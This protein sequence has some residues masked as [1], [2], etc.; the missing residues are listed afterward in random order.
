MRTRVTIAAAALLLASA[1]YAQ[2]QGADQAAPAPTMG[3][4]DFGARATS[5]TGD[6]ARYERYRDLQS[7][8]Y[9]KLV[10]GKATDA[11]LLDVTGEN[12]GYANQ[13][14]SANY[15]NSKLKVTFGWNGIPLNYSYL[16][17]TPYAGPTISGE[18]A[19]YTLDPAVRQGVQEGT[20]F[21]RP[22]NAAGLATPSIYRDLAN[23][24]PL[25]QRRDVVNVGMAYEATRAVGLDVDFTSTRK[26][27]YQPFGAS[28]GFSDGVEMPYPLDQRTNDFSA[29][30]E[31]A[32]QKGMMRVGHQASY[33][34]NAVETMIWD[35][36]VWGP[37]DA[38]FSNGYSTGN[39]ASKG[40]MA[41]PPDNHQNV[42]S[43]TGLYKMPAHTTLNGIFA[44]TDQSQDGR[45]IPF[46]INTA[47]IDN[48]TLYPLHMDRLTAQAQVR[49]YNLAAN[50]NSRPN[51]AI[52]FTLKYRYNKH[53]NLTPHFNGEEYVRFDQ[54][55]EETGSETEQ[56]D[57]TRNTFDAALAFNLPA[58]TTFRVGYGYDK[59]DRTGRGFSGMKDDTFRMSLDTVGNQY[60]T[61]RGAFEHVTRTGE[62][63]SEAS[64]EEGGGQPNLRFYDEADRDRDRASVTVMIT[65]VPMVSINAAYASGKDT[66]KGE[67]HEFGLLD[68]DTTT[69]S[70]G[71]DVSPT[72]LVMFG[73]SYGRDEFTS[74]QKSRNAN[75]PPD[76]SWTDPNRDWYLDN[77]E[78]VNNVDFYLDL[79]KLAGTTDVRFDYI[80]SD[81]DNAFVHYGPRITALRA[82]GQSEALPNVTNKWQRFSADIKYFFT[83]KAGIG[84]GYWYEKFDVE[85]FATIDLPGHDGE[86]RV[87]YLGGLILGYG[88]R[89][90]T[91]S[92][93]FIRLLYLF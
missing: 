64:I 6:A 29:G 19:F 46:T 72:D 73:V 70:F 49:G 69:Y 11:Y 21:G 2:A 44:F 84:L 68:A 35:N 82:I 40:R 3:S 37:T 75:P 13:Q 23:G 90:Y 89:P 79:F 47:I 5:T 76:P 30:L 63:F 15:K 1:T 51:R 4:I 57:V 59:A 36:P 33:F 92:T 20:F 27:G 61:F 55:W 16:T 65:P 87:D 28:F 62:G 38:T 52:G 7:G 53:D 56:F 78:T 71:F 12:I 26:T 77:D 54:V 24:F 83:A 42:I 22:T 86:P 66:Y 32:N 45:L 25:T 10:F 8:V 41:L 31:W 91:G 18:T 17:Q 58:Y 67:G 88:N 14:Y 81:S 93:G 60:V 50:L 39:G 34:T 74:T 9:S 48:P 43:V 80:L 85:D